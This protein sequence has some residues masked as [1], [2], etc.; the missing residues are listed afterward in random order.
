M[1]VQSPRIESVHKECRLNAMLLHSNKRVIDDTETLEPVLIDMP[2]I[3]FISHICMY[4]SRFL[5]DFSILNK[6]STE[7]I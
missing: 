2:S 7:L 1:L 6:E 3:I 4:D 5:I